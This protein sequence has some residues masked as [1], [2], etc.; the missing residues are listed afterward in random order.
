MSTPNETP[1]LALAAYMGDPRAKR[2]WQQSLYTKP[3][4][5]WTRKPRA[6]RLLAAGT[7]P[8]FLFMPPLVVL[9]GYFGP[10]P[11]WTAAL[12]LTLATT[13]TY[14]YVLD[15][16]TFGLCRLADD[17]LDEWQKEMRSRTQGGA[18]RIVT[19]V[20]L[21]AIALLAVSN[22]AVAIIV[23]LIFFI[24]AAVIAPIALTSWRLAS[25][26]TDEA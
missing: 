25:A 10:S 24:E 7:V 12:S 3:A 15:Q 2:K 26:P 5:N 1:G 17:M 16:A 22:D 8:V 18:Y 4:W 14:R 9:V 21:L 6:R 11:M 19:I 20:G 13:L 23:A